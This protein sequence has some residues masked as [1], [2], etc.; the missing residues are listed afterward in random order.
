MFA[1]GNIRERRELPKLVQ[2]D[3]IVVD[4]FAG[5]GYFSLGIA[6]YAKPK[7]IYSIELNPDSFKYLKENIRINKLTKIVTPIQGD[8]AEEILKLSKQNI[9]ADRVIMGVFPAPYEYIKSALSV[10]KPNP[11]PI[12][13]NIETFLENTATKPHY[14]IYESLP[15]MKNT[16]VHFEGVVMGRDFTEFYQK[17]QEPI[18]I[19]GFDCSIVAVRFVKSFGPKM[20]HLVLDLVIGLK[21]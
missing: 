9:R 3:E 21:D 6:K 13:T 11:L 5:I 20:W 8:C 16:L 4:M 7:Q 15:A 18:L 14:D 17:V 12:H 10:V 1:K 2:P 19:S